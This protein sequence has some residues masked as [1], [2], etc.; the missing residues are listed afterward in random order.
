MQFPQHEIRLRTDGIRDVMCKV[1]SR[2][3]LD[4]N[5]IRLDIAP[6]PRHD[7]GIIIRFESV[8]PHCPR[9]LCYMSDVR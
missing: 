1:H 5:E 6:I 7:S 9:S 4:R 8:I 3:S 2:L